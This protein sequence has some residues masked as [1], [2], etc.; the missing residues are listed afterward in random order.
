MYIIS[1][2]YYNIEIKKGLIFLSLTDYKDKPIEK[3]DL[4]R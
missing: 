3:K 4:F 1:P 2:V